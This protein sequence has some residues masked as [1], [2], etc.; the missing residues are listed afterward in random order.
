M[1]AVEAG[2]RLEA[3]YRLY[4]QDKAVTSVIV[5]LIQGAQEVRVNFAL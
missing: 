2:C 1:Y 5:T 4:T 3:P